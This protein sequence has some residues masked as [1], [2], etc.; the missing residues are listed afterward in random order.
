MNTVDE[1]P[2]GEEIETMKI[3]NKKQPIQ[4][5][6]KEITIT[7]VPPTGKCKPRGALT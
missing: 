4:L 3:E 2:P 1:G 5:S 7:A 6:W